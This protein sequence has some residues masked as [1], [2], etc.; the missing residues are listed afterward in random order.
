MTEGG[1]ARLGEIM[2]M[3]YVPRD[4]D[5]ALAFWTEQMGVG[6]FFVRQ[7]VTFERALYR[8]APAEITF[9]MALSYW[10]DIQIELIRPLGEA[11][12]IFSEW[13]RDDG[14]GLHH[15]CVVVDDIG[16]ARAAAEAAGHALLQEAWM[17]G[18]VGEAIYVD[19]GGGP[20]TIVEYIQL[21]PPLLAGFAAMKAAARAWDGSESVRQ[22]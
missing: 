8:G 6:P 21:A 18:G 14:A 17:P 12:G 11:S 7:N 19:T 22:R 13:L 3:A 16:Q 5:A 1:P 2:Q 9:D 4:F 10:G 15:V 20:G